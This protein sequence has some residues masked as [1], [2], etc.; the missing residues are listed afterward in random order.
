[1]GRIGS[2]SFPRTR[3][4]SGVGGQKTLDS[5]LRRNDEPHPA[6]PGLTR[7]SFPRTRESSDLGGQKTLDSGLRR[8]DEPHPVIPGLTRNP[9]LAPNKLLDSGLRRDDVYQVRSNNIPI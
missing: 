3:E 7:S 8:N 2:S 9:A 6:I 5:G 4:S 1:M